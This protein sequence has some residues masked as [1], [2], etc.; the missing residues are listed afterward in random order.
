MKVISNSA[1]TD[2]QDSAS[3]SNDAAAPNEITK[4]EAMRLYESGWWEDKTPREIA[5][6]QMFTRRLCLPFGEF[7]KAVEEALGRPVWTHEFGLNLDGLK[8]E[9]LGEAP[10][11][12]FAE[13]CALIPPEKLILVRS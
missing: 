8:K 7:Q 2:A 1:S 3:V 11:P 12:T 9:L 6:F 4:E 10:A 5:M 13:I